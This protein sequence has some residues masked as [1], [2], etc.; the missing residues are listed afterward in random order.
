MTIKKIYK[1]IVSEKKR[2]NIRLFI[3]KLMYH[4]YLGSNFHCNCCGKNF[5]KL[6][7]KGTTERLNA[8]CP[9]C[10][11]LERTRVLD[12]YLKEELG[13]YEKS[14]MKILH[15]APENCLSRK[16]S[17]IENVVYV[18]GD[19][20]PAN[21]NNII[22][23]TDINY[24]DS[25]FD[26]IICSHVL[27]HVPAEKR[28]I[29]EMKRVLKKDGIAIVMT[30]IDSNR[31]DTFEDETIVDARDRLKYYSE[32]DLCRLHGL[33]FGDRLRK[34]GLKVEEID[35]RKRFSE[36]DQKRMSLGNGNR[37][38]IFRCEKSA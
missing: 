27:G 28:A 34:Q 16:L 19:I 37:E 31:Q 1:S 15:F 17:S 12:L 11:S 20:N 36:K 30:L 25:F 24:D 33:D 18:D 14:G 26:L 4:I 8:K 5:R 22:D 3:E 13:I 35:Y 32:A 10:F 29:Q 9:Y 23:I 21:A 2:V 6:K 38:I 7:S